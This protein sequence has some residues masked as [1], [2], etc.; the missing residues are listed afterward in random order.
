MNENIYAKIKWEKMKKILLF[1]LTI[2][3]I[4]AFGQNS[5]D[6]IQMYI[7]EKTF[8]A[9]EELTLD[10]WTDQLDGLAAW[11][12]RLNFENAEILDLQEGASFD[13]I[14][15]NIFNDGK[16]IN[17]IWLPADVQSID[18]PSNETWFTITVLPSVDG[19][20][21][22]IFTT[23][24]DPWS[25]IVLE[26]S[27]D[28]SGVNADFS[29]QIEERSFLVANE[30]VETDNLRILNNPIRDRLVV[31]GLSRNM[32]ISQVEVVSMNGSL[33][34]KSLIDTQSTDVNID[35]ADIQAGIYFLK[36]NGSSQK[37]IKFIKI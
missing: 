7:E 15:H 13:D 5:Q 26:D 28:I 27:T 33:V 8:T 21:F 20:T 10:I 23:E 36:L 35:V 24:N 12:L 17:T 30:E 37:T 11:Q 2:L 22:D 19:S 4:S 6:T 14:P 34:L 16:T 9:G 29:F 31:T 25:E 18:M 3:S 32:G 1:A